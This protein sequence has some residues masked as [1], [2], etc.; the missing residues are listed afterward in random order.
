MLRQLSVH[1]FTQ[2][3]GKIKRG[4]I[5]GKTFPGGG[6]IYPVVYLQVVFPVFKIK[7]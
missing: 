5:F 4:Y 1:R 6:G 3:V 2:Q 7:N